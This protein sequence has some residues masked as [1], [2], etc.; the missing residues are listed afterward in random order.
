MG[1]VLDCSVAL[2]WVLPDEDSDY[3]DAVLDR[4]VDDSAMVPGLWPLEVGNVLLVA[5]RRRRIERDDVTRAVH[6]LQALPIVIDAHTHRHALADTV[7]LGIAHGVTTYDAAYLEL[8]RRMHLP[9][10]TLDR[11]LRRAAQDAGVDLLTI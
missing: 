3:A 4:L 11:G 7:A 6:A 2:A 10:A 1:F 9:L 5:L 8:A